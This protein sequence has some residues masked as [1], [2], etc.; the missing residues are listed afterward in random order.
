MVVRAYMR[1]CAGALYDW[2]DKNYYGVMCAS[3]LHAFYD[4]HPQCKDTVKQNGSLQFCKHFKRLFR[5][6]DNWI[7]IVPNDTHAFDQAI[8]ILYSSSS[9]HMQSLEE[10]ESYLCKLSHAH[11]SISK[12]KR[13]M[14]EYGVCLT[15]GV[16]YGKKLRSTLQQNPRLMLARK[17]LRHL[18]TVKKLLITL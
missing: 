16:S 14:R 15:N 10:L 6:R 1:N 17:H 2:I 13:F 11:E 4:A 8:H 3:E 9:T 12:F 18:P 7:C 5:V